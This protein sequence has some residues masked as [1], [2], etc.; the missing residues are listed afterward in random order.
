MFL[1]WNDV[2]KIFSILSCKSY[3]RSKEFVLLLVYFGA[4]TIRFAHDSFSGVKTYMAF[5][6][7]KVFIL[8]CSTH[9]IVSFFTK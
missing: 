9:L 8:I 3:A 2:L 1:G 4:H 6:I 5:Q 7:F